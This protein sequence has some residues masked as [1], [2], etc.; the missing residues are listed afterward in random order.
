M[1]EDSANSPI[2]VVEFRATAPKRPLPGLDDA[3]VKLR[4][5]K[6]EL[7]LVNGLLSGTSTHSAFKQTA[8]EMEQI[9]KTNPLTKNA[10]KLSPS[11]VA[12]ALGV[13]DEKDFNTFLNRFKANQKTLAKTMF[14]GTDFASAG[15][16]AEFTRKY[17]IAADRARDEHVSKLQALFNQGVIPK[18]GG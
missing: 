1:A 8:K 16:A 12:Q 3:L 6:T 9:L 11:Q 5:L 15:K 10:K 13:P 14:S 17:F 4:Q 2:E 7:D 18:A